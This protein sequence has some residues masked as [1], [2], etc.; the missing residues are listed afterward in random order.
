MYGRFAAR[1]FKKLCLGASGVMV[2]LLGLVPNGLIRLLLLVFCSGGRNYHRGQRADRYINTLSRGAARSKRCT[3]DKNQQTL[4]S[5]EG[6]HTHDL[7]KRALLFTD[8]RET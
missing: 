7:S 4:L 3:S 1:L 2:Q 8:L 6:W 5:K